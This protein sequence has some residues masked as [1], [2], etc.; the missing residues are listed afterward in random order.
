MDG[1]HGVDTRVRVETVTL[2]QTTNAPNRTNP[3][4]GV[5]YYCPPNID[6]GGKIEVNIY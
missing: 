6:N 1:K 3:I 4:R 2:I 5:N